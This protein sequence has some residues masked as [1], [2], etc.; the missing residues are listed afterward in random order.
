[1]GLGNILL[2]D[3]GFGVHFIRWLEKRWQ[4]PKEMELI[5]GG[6]MAFALLD[7]ICSCDYLI[8]ID[9]LKT[10]DEPGTLYRFTLEE[11]EPKLPPPSSAHEVQLLDVLQQ[12]EILGECP[13][14]IFLCTVPAEIKE[15]DLELSP[16]MRERF[17]AVEALLLKELAHHGLVPLRYHA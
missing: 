5:E 7:P 15:M 8:I 2:K 16:F 9:V 11:L 6:V 17:P 1:M 3:E 12:A 14:V 13:E 4:F 10:S